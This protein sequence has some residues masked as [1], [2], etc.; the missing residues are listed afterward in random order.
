MFKNYMKI[1][2]RNLLKHKAYSF[3]NILGLAVGIAASVLI[4]LYVRDESSYDRFHAKADRI[5]RITADWS[6]KGD[7]RIHQ[8]GTPSVLARTIRDKYPQAES[9]TQ[10]CG[11]LGDIFLKY[12]DNNLKE[13]DVYL[14][15]PSFFEIFTFPLASGDSRTALKDPNTVVLSQALATKLFG[16]E[17]ALGK[18]VQI[19]VMGG[20][21][22]YLITGVAGNVPLNSHFR[23]ELLVSMTSYFKGNETG[24]TS[25]NFSTYLLLRNGVTQ[26]LMEDKLVELEMTYL[27][28]GRPHQPWIW[29]LEPITRIHLDSDLATGARLTSSSSAWS[30]SSSFSSPG[31]ISSICQRPVRPREPGRWA[32][33]KPSAPSEASSSGNFWGNRSSSAYSPFSWRSGSSN[34]LCRSIGI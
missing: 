3:I 30:P 17:D 23:F 9:V 8:L 12:R 25:N 26:K 34:W 21:K 1:A 6:N 29:T 24:W 15:E 32:S 16:K 31:S 28:A 18:T 20:E 19:Q 2:V 14:A 33:A 11:P 27:A 5:Y 22:P 10:L 4:F 13:T 7:S